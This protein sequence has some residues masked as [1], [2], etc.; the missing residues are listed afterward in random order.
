MKKV[1]YICISEKNEVLLCYRGLTLSFVYTDDN[2]RRVRW[3]PR[4]NMGRLIK[5]LEN[6]KVSINEHLLSISHSKH[7][8]EISEKISNKLLD[9]HGVEVRD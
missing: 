7:K 3:D 8:I 6:S 9:I 1:Y 5:F 4:K 2:D